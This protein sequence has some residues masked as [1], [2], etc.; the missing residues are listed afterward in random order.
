MGVEDDEVAAIDLDGG[1]QK[2]P[3]EIFLSP[4][5]RPS[6]QLFMTAGE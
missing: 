6:K 4:G 5:R 3:E 1:M 2:P